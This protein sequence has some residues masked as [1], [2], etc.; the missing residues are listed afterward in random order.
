MQNSTTA[1]TS[2]FQNC[3]VLGVGLGFRRELYEE[4]L[5]SKHL[6]DW[7]EVTP[8]NHM[9]LGG[10]S[11][12]MIEDALPL[13]PL[14]SHGVSLS[15]GGT[16]DWDKTYL[17]DLKDFF[18]WINPPW[19]SDHLSF[20]R[21]QGV[22]L[23][24]LIPLPATQDVVTH[25][26]DRI[27]FL[28]DYFQRPVLI[29][30]V[31]YYLTYPQSTLEDADFL[32]AILEKADC[33]LLLDVNNV[34]VNASNHGFNPERYIEALP[35]NRV[36]QIHV[37]GHGYYEDEPVQRIDTH[38]EAVCKDVWDLLSWTLGRCKPCGV[39]IERDNNFPPFSEI[40]PE[41]ETCRH[42]WNETQGLILNS[43]KLEVAV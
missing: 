33:G 35:L 13:F 32:T 9:A 15:I 27:H 16:D 23:H 31:S 19:F 24:D 26:A 20:A 34:Y 14:V 30:N 25:V 41:I 4:T 22:Y 5:Q 39:M 6:L 3:P 18:D 42:I 43:N 8:E 1:Q 17:K 2:G 10:E 38:G 40:I 36:V 21:H 37:A 28:Q 29:E 12:K 11:H 7:L